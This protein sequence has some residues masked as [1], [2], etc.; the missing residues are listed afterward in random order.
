MNKKDLLLSHLFSFDYARFVWAFRSVLATLICMIFANYF[1][2]TGLWLI[3]SA[4]FALQ[5]YAYG[6]RICAKNKIFIGSLLLALASAT[7]AVFSGSIFVLWSMV[8]ALVCVSFYF[9]YQGIDRAMLGVWSIALIIIN[10]FFPI[11]WSQ[12]S[13][14]ACPLLIGAAVAYFLLFI[15]IPR[16]KKDK[17]IVQLQDIALPFQAYM[18]HVFHHL[19]FDDLPTNHRYSYDEVCAALSRLRDLSQTVQCTYNVKYPEIKVLLE[20]FYSSYVN[21]FYWLVALE[22]FQVIFLPADRKFDLEH[23]RTSFQSVSYSMQQLLLV[24]KPDKNNALK[25]IHYLLNKI[26]DAENL[27]QLTEQQ[28]ISIAG[29][30]YIFK[31]LAEEKE[32]F[33]LFLE[34]TAAQNSIRYLQDL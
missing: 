3:S 20:N 16:R 21:I 9:S 13:G 31:K 1:P 17:I 29:L 15:K 25:S 24:S 10:V 19:L 32:N 22:R 14:R 26:K 6:S 8:V 4:V 12:W 7:F 11:D 33:I 28:R 23:L 27:N 18:D 2:N 30:S 5:L 34:S